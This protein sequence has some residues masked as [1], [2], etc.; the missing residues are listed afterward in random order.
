MIVIKMCGES[1][2][3]GEV[4]KKSETRYNFCLAEIRKRLGIEE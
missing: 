1:S 4:T 2:R 3:R